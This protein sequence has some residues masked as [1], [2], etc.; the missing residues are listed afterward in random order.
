MKITILNDNVPGRHCLSE[1]GLSY[2][3]EADKKILFDTGSTDVFLRNSRLIN[4]SLTDIDA[5]VLSHG[6]WDHGNGLSN[7]QGYKLIC[8]P[9]VFKKRYNK[10]NRQYIGLKLTMAEINER[11]QLITTATPFY[12]S[13]EMI[14]LGEIP[15]LN[16][17]EATS[18]H[19]YDETGNDDF[20]DDDSALAVITGKGL[21]IISG[22][23]HAGICNTIDY[24]MKIT[25]INKINAVIGGFHLKSDEGRTMKTIQYLKKLDIPNIYPSHCTSLSALA[26]F[27][28][29]FKIHQVV[30]GDYF[31]F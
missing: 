29:A 24:A 11:F 6:H 27:Y 14:F 16:D 1:F 23:A 2:L 31:N 9:G 28:E 26:K 20:V 5:V 4:V 22:C 30:T 10:K 12:I 8:H 17:F 13:P 25:G 18:T 7:I 15:R 21:V 19:F 3:V